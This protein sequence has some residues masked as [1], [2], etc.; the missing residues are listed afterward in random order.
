M[1]KIFKLKCSYSNLNLTCLSGCGWEYKWVPGPEPSF[2]T[3]MCCLAGGYFSSKIFFIPFQVFF[4]LF[5]IFVILFQFFFILFQTFLPFLMSFCGLSL[6]FLICLMLHLLN[7]RKF[8]SCEIFSLSE[9]CYC[10]LIVM[11]S[12]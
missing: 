6:T 10:F 12:N 7:F 5:Q 3:Q 9:L 11:S 4:I 2:I 1:L 8:G